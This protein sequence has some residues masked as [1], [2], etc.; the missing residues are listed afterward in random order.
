MQA[1]A[2]A[3]IRAAEDAVRTD[4]RTDP[5]LLARLAASY[6]GAGRFAQAIDTAQEA[7][8]RAEAIGDAKLA[9]GIEGYLDSWRAAALQ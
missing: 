6:A 9:H 4:R 2:G 5:M 7:L 8:A 1:E 3:A